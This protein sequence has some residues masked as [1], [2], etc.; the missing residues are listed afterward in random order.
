MTYIHHPLMRTNSG[1]VFCVQCDT[2]GPAC[3]NLRLVCGNACPWANSAT[4]FWTHSASL[5]G[6]PPATG[7]S[8]ALFKQILSHD[9]HLNPSKVSRQHWQSQR[10]IAWLLLPLASWHRVPVITLGSSQPTKG[11]CQSVCEHRQHYHSNDHF[12]NTHHHLLL[13]PICGQTWKES[14]PPASIR[15]CHSAGFLVPK[16]SSKPSRGSRKSYPLIVHIT[17]FL[18]GI[19]W[20]CTFLQNRFDSIEGGE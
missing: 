14:F 12:N 18:A 7:F 11:V 5:E 2:Q 19:V 20:K 3:T 9:V 8:G 16:V 10:F 1:V 6:K 17:P 13:L 15:S 4:P